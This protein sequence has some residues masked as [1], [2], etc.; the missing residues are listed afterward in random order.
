MVSRQKMKNITIALSEIF[1]ENIEILV[2]E[3]RVPSRSEAIRI[4]IRNFLKKEF[5]FAGNLGYEIQKQI[6][7]I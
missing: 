7:K 2:Q 5:E 1:V 3:G 4:A 6:D